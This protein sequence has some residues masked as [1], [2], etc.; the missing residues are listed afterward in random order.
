MYDSD[1]S[2]EEWRLIEHYFQ[3]Q[4]RRGAAPK[5]AK[6]DIVNAI[7]YINGTGAKWRMLPKDFPPW[8]TVYDH[9]NNWNRRRVWQAALYDL[10]ALHRKKTAKR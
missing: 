10:Y 8:Q 4:D 3:P 9:Y 6:R 7:L 2:D 5:H 1:L